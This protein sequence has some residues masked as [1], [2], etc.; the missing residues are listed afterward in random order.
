MKT[1][2]VIVLCAFL[3]L[4]L[5]LLF[6][7][8][9]YVHQEP[10]KNNR[11]RKQHGGTGSKDTMMSDDHAFQ[12]SVNSSDTIDLLNDELDKTADV[13]RGSSLSSL[14]YIVR[15]NVNDCNSNLL[16]LIA[17]CSSVQNFERRQAIRLTWGRKTL[18]VN[19][20]FVTALPT[21]EHQHLQTYIW[22]EST[23]YGDIVQLSHVDH[24]KNLSLKSIGMLQWTIE[25]CRSSRF[26][27]KTDDD[28][29]LN[30]PNLM[31]LLGTV[32]APGKNGLI[33]GSII[34]GARPIKDRLS[35]WY[36]PQSVF[37]GSVYPTYASGTAYLISRDVVEKLLKLTSKR[38]I[39]WLEDIYLT[40][41]LAKELDV[42]LLNDD[43]FNYLK[44]KR[45][46]CLFLK[47][48]TEHGIGP[49]ELLQIW[50]EVLPKNKNYC[51]DS[52]ALA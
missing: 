22:K 18:Q 46:A 3:C 35:K 24:Y 21:P 38:P 10:P 44:R 4:N 20:V 52:F 41:I 34:Q 47:T 40:G 43:R 36:T 17:V 2:K 29:F 8:T 11:N 14:K 51:N 23:T 7:V 12:N 9:F 13:V 50:N 37:K 31:N 30:L 45:N 15:P 49:K 19:I 32:P 39:F 1:W 42:E 5:M 6:Y 48:I 28:V 25:H 27:L 33:L 16:L 26:L